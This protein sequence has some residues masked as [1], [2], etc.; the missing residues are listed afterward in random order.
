MSKST[1]P[2]AGPVHGLYLVV[3]D[4]IAGYEAC[5]EAAVR[6]G[7]RTVQLR[8]K[9]ATREERRRRGRTLRSITR[10]TPTHFIVNDDPALAEEVEAEGVHLGQ[11]DM[12]LDEARRRHP[13]LRFFGLSTHNA[14]QA[15]SAL[16]C[17]PDYIGVGPVFATPTK[18]KPDP[19]LGCAEA[20]RI[21]RAVAIPA[22]AIGGIDAQTLPEVLA[23]GAVHF[24]VVRTVCNA[25]R[26]FDAIRRLQDLWL[27]T[28]EGKIRD[29]P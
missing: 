20:G 11:T 21:I 28:L 19:V 4:P 10:G 26:P 25:P 23:A 15:A 13:G 22:V 17:A 8:M 12:P 6:A 1:E 24:A 27:A 3:T 2:D 16:A 5:A 9:H 14:A 7:V 29:R 18:E